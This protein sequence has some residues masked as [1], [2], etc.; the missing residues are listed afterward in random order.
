MFIKVTYNDNT[1][2]CYNN[3]N[4]ITDNINVI[5]INCSYTV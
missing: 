2:V 4:R 1:V 5:Q 3:F